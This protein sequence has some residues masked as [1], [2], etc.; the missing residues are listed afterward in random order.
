[1]SSRYS[2][3]IVNK[4]KLYFSNPTIYNLGGDINIKSTD[5]PDSIA[6]QLYNF[7]F[8]HYENIFYDDEI[9]DNPL[10][11]IISNEKITDSILYDLI[12]R[13]GFKTLDIKIHDLAD[14]IHGIVLYNNILNHN[15]YD[16]REKLYLSNLTKQELFEM[17]KIT[18]DYNELILE[19]NVSHS[20]LLLYFYVGIKI[21]IPFIDN[22]FNL[23]SAKVFNISRRNV[24]KILSKQYIPYINF[25][26]KNIMSDTIDE[27]KIIPILKYGPYNALAHSYIANELTDDL[28][29]FNILNLLDENTVDYIGDKY[30]IDYP[31]DSY[32]DNSSARVDFITEYLITA[33]IKSLLSRNIDNIKKV[34]IPN[35]I[36]SINTIMYLLRFLTLR[37][38]TY[39]YKIKSR[40]NNKSKNLDEW[41][42]SSV[43]EHI[44]LKS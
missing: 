29:I 21:D 14:F 5:E 4:H 23:L 24:Y 33:N 40:F 22:S 39:L 35:N 28:I 30:D 12:D 37:E 3:S 25:N 20:M 36:T 26:A 19:Q 9:I 42:S 15:L 1:M 34:E 13:I 2:N 6:D 38:I 7:I 18:D 31:Y 8:Y 17:Y 27:N 10:S 43:Y 16:E 44:F 41:T 32:Y 11:F